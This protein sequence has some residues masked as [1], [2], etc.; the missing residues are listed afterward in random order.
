M[1]TV[2]SIVHVNTPKGTAQILLHKDCE[3]LH[4]VACHPKQP[5]VAMGNERGVL[6]VW[7]Y[8]NKVII[9]SRVFKTEK[10]IQCV[11]F[12]PQGEPVRLLIVSAP[13]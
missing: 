10:N 12:D 6:N 5:T 4:T 8:N 7:D 13:A 1:S 2:S 9:C 3:P 11:T